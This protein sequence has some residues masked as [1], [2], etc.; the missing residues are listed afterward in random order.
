MKK[1]STTLSA[2]LLFSVLGTAASAAA[3]PSFHSFWG[4]HSYDTYQGYSAAGP[5]RI[6]ATS[7]TA[8]ADPAVERVIDAGFRYLGTPYE[9]GSNRADAKTF[10]CSDFV[11]QAFLE[12]ADAKLPGDSRKQGAFVRELGAV[13]TSWRELQRGDLMFFMSYEGSKAS[14]YR[15]VDPFEER[16]THVAIYLGDGKMLHTYSEDSGGVRTDD[17][18]GAWEYRFLYGGSALVQD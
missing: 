13:K 15:G 10:D 5:T 6:A 14:D 9:F 8:S 7:V 1:L 11:K 2:V 17:V 12:G 3:A 16:I 18:D 4:F